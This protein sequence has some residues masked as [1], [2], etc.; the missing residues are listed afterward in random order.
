M[1]N[2][3]KLDNYLAPDRA[4]E[5]D[6]YDMKIDAIINGLEGRSS[7]ISAQSSTITGT[8]TKTYFDKILT[9]PPGALTAGKSITVKALLTVTSP[10]LATNLTVDL[11]IFAPT[12]INLYTTGAFDPADGTTKYML[13]WKGLV[14]EKNLLQQTGDRWYN[15]TTGVATAIPP[16]F[17]DVAFNED[18]STPIKLAATWAANDANEVFVVQF[19]YTIN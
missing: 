8:N 9:I 19:S 13:E 7:S 1:S 10:M 4:T 2:I 3:Y 18:S 5:G 14:S 16:S 12:A 17:Y 6:H 15:I 11:D